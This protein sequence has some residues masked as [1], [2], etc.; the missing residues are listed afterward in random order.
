MITSE[1][2][3]YR[4]K[5]QNSLD[6][7]QCQIVYHDRVKDKQMHVPFHE[8]IPMEK[9]GDIP[10]H[11]VYTILYQGQ[12]L[13]D[14]HNRIFNQELILDNQELIS[15]TKLYFSHGTD[16]EDLLDNLPEDFTIVTY[17]CLFD[18]YT[19]PGLSPVEK[20][21][22]GLSS[23]LAPMTADILCFQE[24]TPEMKT[25]ILKKFPG[26]CL[27]DSITEKYGQIILSKVKPIAQNVFHFEGNK[28]K[29]YLRMT[30]KTF[31]GSLINLFNLHLTSGHQV[32]S[33]EKRK[34]QMDQ[35]LKEIDNQQKYLL[36]GDFNEAGDI[37]L[38][39]GDA[40]DVWTHLKGSQKGL[41]YDSVENSLAS[42]N[43]AKGV[44]G[45]FDR[46]IFSGLNPL[47]IEIIGNI[48]HQGIWLSDHYGLKT[49]L[50]SSD[51][52]Q[53]SFNFEPPKEDLEFKPGFALDIFLNPSKWKW[54]NNWR[55]KYDRSVKKWSPHITLFMFF[56]KP[57]QW[58]IWR[59]ILL[60]IYQNELYQ[61]K[62]IQFNQVEIFQQDLR[63]TIVL[64]SSQKSKT[65]DKFHRDLEKVF[66]ITSG[67]E[68]RPH[69]TLGSLPTLENALRVQKEINLKIQTD[70][71]PTG[72]QVPFD[73]IS[74]VNCSRD[75]AQVLDCFVSDQHSQF[76]D[77]VQFVK[78][79]LEIFNLNLS[80]Q[81]TLVGSRSYGIQSGDYDI[82]IS[83]SQPQSE[84]FDLFN[85][86][87]RSLPSCLYCEIVESRVPIINIKMK[88]N[89]KGQ[90]DLNLIYQELGVKNELKNELKNKLIQ[91]ILDVPR[92]VKTHLKKYQFSLEDFSLKFEMIKKWFQ[93]K[94]IYGANYGYFNGI[95]L[96]V[97]VLRLIIDNPETKTETKFD[98]FKSFL[99]K[100]STWNWKISIISIDSESA[101]HQ[102]YRRRFPSDNV[103]VILVPGLPSNILRK[104]TP[105]HLK[106]IQ[107][108]MIKGLR[109]IENHD[110]ETA[111]KIL[112][113]SRIIK[114]PRL[115]L[116]VKSDFD[117]HLHRKTNWISSQ[118]WRIFIKLEPYTFNPDC[119][120]KVK[121]GTYK[122]CFGL[123]CSIDYIHDLLT[124]FNCDYTLCD[125]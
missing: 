83:G 105:T 14:R 15:N 32:G 91:N 122:Y 44:Q 107:D 13:W 3:Y 12:V 110:P 37:E 67:Q 96:V 66:G 56:I 31:D 1:K 123:S 46:I 81:V 38:E 92:I 62:I 4:I 2:V 25:I 80:C 84:I 51:L 45:R 70:F 41:T 61:N 104:I 33:K 57:E 11:R 118:I 64:V 47:E 98:F 63:N 49:V 20:R 34:I 26:Y 120:W 6:T 112:G 69:I 86:I 24:I 74:Y 116:E 36:V 113:C 119:E 39:N 106:I 88:G 71:G 59:P 125:A 75:G 5:W 60:K 8:W 58:L 7:S 100:Y 85:Q 9:G 65:I 21:L 124:S 99:K 28:V 30:F 48:P 23:L 108:Q 68:F 90:I 78:E 27:S 19:L 111:Q 50:N 55:L 29:T 17:N 76:E 87:F 93:I 18:L 10:W 94:K 102:K 43:S 114:G 16:P 73:N 52:E 115:E 72:I 22:D 77:P 95:A 82:L 35:I 101:D 121:N 89:M 97:M 79:I 40:Q 103:A 109:T 53:E 42:S 54:I 117:F